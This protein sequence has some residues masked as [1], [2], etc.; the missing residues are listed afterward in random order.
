MECIF[1]KI[2]QGKL[3][4]KK[5]FET[6]NV[7]VIENINKEA[8]YHAL[9]MPKRH[10]SLAQ[11]EE[12][13]KALLGELI[14]AARQIGNEDLPDG[15]RLIINNGRDANQDIEHLH[16]HLVGGENLGRLLAE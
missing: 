15:Y 1:C 14:F 3:E 6:E 5:L 11:A 10:L 8:P 4:S 13:D 7:L 2:S 12:S 16:I 9:V